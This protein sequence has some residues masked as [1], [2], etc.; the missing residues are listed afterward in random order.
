VDFES[1]TITL[2]YRKNPA[3]P[4][5]SWQVEV[6]TDLQR[7][8]VVPDVLVSSEEGIE[9]RRAAVNAGNERTFLRLRVT[10]LF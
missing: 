5:V 6:S 4:D 2:S 7:W 9:V 10:K 8:E 3:L 1:G